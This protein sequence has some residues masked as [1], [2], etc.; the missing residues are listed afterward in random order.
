[1]S[2]GQAATI[3]L[4]LGLLVS[5]V[6]FGMSSDLVSSGD[7]GRPDAVPADAV[8]LAD[9]FGGSYWVSCGAA[10]SKITCNAYSEK[11]AHV[12]EATYVPRDDKQAAPPFTDIV[13]SDVER[14]YLNK[15]AMVPDGQVAFP[16]ASQQ[17]TYNDGNRLK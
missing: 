4:F 15:V 11:G 8:W 13:A 12:L 7:P 9:A 6:V 17:F 2:G 10:K 3:G 16:H 14:V 1:M 5:A